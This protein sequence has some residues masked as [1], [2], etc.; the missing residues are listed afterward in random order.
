[1]FRADYFGAE[2]SFAAQGENMHRPNCG[3]I[4]SIG[5]YTGNVQVLILFTKSRPK[6]DLQPFLHAVVHKL[7]LP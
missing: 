4:L 3:S 7:P 2:E 6:P 1:M 5:L